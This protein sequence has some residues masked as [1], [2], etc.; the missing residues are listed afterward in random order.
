MAEPKA[1]PGPSEERYR[2]HDRIRQVGELKQD[3]QQR[4]D[5]ARGKITFERRGFG[6]VDGERGAGEHR[7]GCDEDREGPGDRKDEGSLPVRQQPDQ[8]RPGC[9]RPGAAE[10]PAANASR[11]PHATACGSDADSL[12]DRLAIASAVVSSAYGTARATAA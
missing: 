9:Q 5:G 6:Q 1:K 7:P 10:P 4:A 3:E 2:P 8:P 11:K 12:A